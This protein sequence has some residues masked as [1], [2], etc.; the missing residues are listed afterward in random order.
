MTPA[1][2]PWLAVRA[3]LPKSELHH[4]DHRRRSIEQ[5]G[6]DYVD[7]YLVHWPGG[8][9]TWAWPGMGAARTRNYAR[10]IGVSNFDA[11]ELGPQT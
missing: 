1:T 8:G 9:A 6:V 5:P 3:R 4:R 7:L 11:A 10:A 2:V